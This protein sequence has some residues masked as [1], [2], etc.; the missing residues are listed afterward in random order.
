MNH[1]SR[2]EFVKRYPMTI[3]VHRVSGVHAEPAVID[4][5]ASLGGIYQH[6]LTI[7]AGAK[8]VGHAIVKGDLVVERGALLY[9]DGGIVDGTMRVHGAAC[10][11]G[12]F[13]TME[14]DAE[15]VVSIDP[16]SKIKELN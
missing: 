16:E 13:G 5:D 3:P 6:G 9:F 12:I 4:R 8:V 15:A 7:R 2:E 10:L 1:I 11:A 14:G